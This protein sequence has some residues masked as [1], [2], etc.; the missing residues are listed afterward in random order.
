LIYGLLGKK[1]GHSLSPQIHSLFGEYP[2]ELFCREENELD[3]FFADEKITAFNVTVPYK[4]KAIN[5]CD[6]I[7]ETAKKIG[8]VN[9]VVR[10]EKGK[11]HGY[12]TDYFG[13]KYM[14]Q[15]YGADFK[16]KKVLI[17]GNGGASRS[18]HAVAEDG[19]AREIIIVSRTGENNYGNLD[20]HFDADI[21][22]NTTPVGMFPNNSEKLIDLAMFISLSCVLDLIYNPMKTALLI[23]AEKLGIPNG[24]GLS[25]LVAQ[26]LRSAELF[27]D[28][29]LDES[30]IENAYSKIK[31]D[32]Q[33]IVMIGMPG[34]GKSMLAKIL[35]KKL[36]RV[37]IDT[38]T[39]IEDKTSKKIPDI[40]SENGEEFFRKIETEIVKESGKKLGAIIATGGGAVLKEENRNALSQNGL[41]VY[42]KRDISSLATDNRPLSENE[43]AIR[44]L[45]NERRE[46]YESF[47]DITVDVDSDAETTANRI[48]EE[49]K[50]Q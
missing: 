22:V 41:I 38:D 18:V 44:K 29:K 8:S 17:L 5:R 48:I 28:K 40:F 39:K 21:I 16:N 35:A 19:G 12:N 15:K 46:I 43:D 10:D 34:C 2:Y 4:I 36:D 50:K 14:A 32:T 30:L 26:G 9:T 6:F 49:L 11:L 1:L 25:M 45:Y 37:L 7:S 27:F 3:E 42:L 24:N 13:F 31:N 23:D 33:N 20:R 47:A